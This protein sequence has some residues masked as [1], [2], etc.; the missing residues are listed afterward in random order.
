MKYNEEVTC[1]NNIVH[2]II[3]HYS[4]HYIKIGYNVSFLLV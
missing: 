1:K 2:Y 4:F 3:I